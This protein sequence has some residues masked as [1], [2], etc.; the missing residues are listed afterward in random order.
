MRLTL[1]GPGGD[2]LTRV[3]ATTGSPGYGS[4]ARLGPYRTK[5]REHQPAA[6]AP[7]R[8]PLRTRV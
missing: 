3:T 2:P 8:Q 7:S 1:L 6:P 5:R 4:S